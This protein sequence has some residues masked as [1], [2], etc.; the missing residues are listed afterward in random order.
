MD[1]LIEVLPWAWEGYYG[2]T[3]KVSKK[4]NMQKYTSDWNVRNI[5]DVDRS[6]HWKYKLSF[7]RLIDKRD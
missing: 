3:I 6:I 7:Q 4:I 1:R 2:V 5:G